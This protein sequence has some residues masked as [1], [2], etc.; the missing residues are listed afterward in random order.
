MSDSFSRAM[1]ACRSSL[2]LELTRTSSPWICAFTPLGPWS[3]II[4]VICFA[5]SWFSPSRSGA[6]SL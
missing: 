1:T 4:L 6:T 2:D 5:M 3:L